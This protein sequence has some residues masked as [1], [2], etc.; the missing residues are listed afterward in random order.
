ML[1]VVRNYE[2]E[3]RLVLPKEQ[4]G[5]HFRLYSSAGGKIFRFQLSPVL[6]YHA[7]AEIKVIK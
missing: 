2:I 6:Q 3:E 4:A 5:S 7:E 1:R